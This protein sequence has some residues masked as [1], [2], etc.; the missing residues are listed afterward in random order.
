MC[1]LHFLEDEQQQSWVKEMGYYVMNMTNKSGGSTRMQ[2]LPI[3]LI[4]FKPFNPKTTEELILDKALTQT[5]DGTS[6]RGA[7]HGKQWGTEKPTIITKSPEVPTKAV[8]QLFFG[9]LNPDYSSERLIQSVKDHFKVVNLPI[10]EVVVDHNGLRQGVSIKLSS[11]I[12]PNQFIKAAAL[13]YVKVLHRL[14]L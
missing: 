1:H 14:V 10:S 9:W 2:V 8:S 4:Q 6:Q 3:Q 12:E 5:R 13:R 11:S 7:L